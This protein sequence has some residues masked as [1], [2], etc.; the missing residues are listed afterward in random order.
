MSHRRVNIQVR[1][2]V[3]SSAAVERVAAVMRMG[4]VS[5]GGKYYCWVTTF[6]DGTVVCVRGPNAR[7]AETSDSFVVYKEEKDG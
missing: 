4:R 2:G 6:T 7:A 3:D 1:D 5:G